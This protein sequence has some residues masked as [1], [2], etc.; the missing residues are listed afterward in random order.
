VYATTEAAST[1]TV[2]SDLPVMRT[3]RSRNNR[4]RLKDGQTRQLTTA[5]D[6]ISGEMVRVDVTL[7]VVK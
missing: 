5:V 2:Q 1:S 4:V 7:T 3:F 6:R